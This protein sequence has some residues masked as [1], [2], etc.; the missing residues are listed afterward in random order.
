[1]KRLLSLIVCLCIIISVSTTVHAAEQENVLFYQVTDLGNGLTVIDEIV[2]CPQARTTY[3]KTVN[4][5]RTL[6]DGDT[7]IAVIVFQATFHYDGTTVSVASK[8]IIQCDT[9]DGWTF[10]QS[11]FTS[12]GGTVSLTGKLTKWLIFNSSTFTMSLTC[13]KDGNV[14]YH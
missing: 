12:S 10:N 1:M 8:S 2:E 9:Y 7:V 3:G 13:D 14:T 6:K 11:S 5:S 4:R